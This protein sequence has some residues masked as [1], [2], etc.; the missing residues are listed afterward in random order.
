MV[1]QQAVAVQLE[2][3]LDLAGEGFQLAQLGGR[4]LARTPVD[5]A[6]GAEHM[7][8][9]GHQRDAGVEADVRRVGD[10]R[11]AGEALIGVGVLDQ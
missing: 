7:V 6:Q 10:Q 2:Q 3:L 8:A 5:D 4:Q 1:E 11:V 9:I